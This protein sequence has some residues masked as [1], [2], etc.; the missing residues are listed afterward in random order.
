MLNQEIAKDLNKNSVIDILRN[1]QTRVK[2]QKEKTREHAKNL[3]YS[4]ATE[5]QYRAYGLQDALDAIE[6]ILK[7][8]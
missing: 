1:L 4:Q 7:N 3:N 8:S 5:A 2:I 6:D